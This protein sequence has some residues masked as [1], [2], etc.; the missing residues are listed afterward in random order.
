[1]DPAGLSPDYA[2]IRPNIAPSGSGFSDFMIRHAPDR[3]GLVELLGF[4]SPGLTSSLAVGEHVA[5]M[6]RREV[7]RDDWRD[8]EDE[9]LGWE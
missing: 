7:W 4:N 8:I 9:A 3:R 1:V 5:R 6:V 2:G